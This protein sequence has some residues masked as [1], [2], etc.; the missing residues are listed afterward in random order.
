MI[1]VR[2]EVIRKPNDTCKASSNQEANEWQNW[3][4]ASIDCAS[5]DCTI[6]QW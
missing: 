3:F 2:L 6:L 1:H 4:C 5:I